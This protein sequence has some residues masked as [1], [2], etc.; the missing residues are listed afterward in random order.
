MAAR[1]GGD[2]W[3]GHD[4][5]M[6]RPEPRRG[7]LTVNTHNGVTKPADEPFKPNSHGIRCYHGD[8]VSEA[9][10]HWGTYNGSDSDMRVALE[11]ISS[12]EAKAGAVFEAF[13]IEMYV[14]V[15]FSDR[16]DTV[17]AYISTGFVDSVVQAVDTQVLINRG[18]WRHEFS[19]YGRHGSTASPTGS[20]A[21]TV[22][23]ECPCSPGLQAPIGSECSRCEEPIS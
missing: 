13:H 5:I 6:S 10:K 9:I 20:G 4:G 15:T 14:A 2:H 23:G 1:S 16:P 11:L 12:Q 17:G 21:T 8:D 19:G 22:H 3:L 7:E 18:Y